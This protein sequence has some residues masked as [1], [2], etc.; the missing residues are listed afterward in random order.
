MAEFVPLVEAL[1][2]GDPA[3]EET[4]VGPLIDE[5]ARERVL[6]WI[7]ETSGEVLT[8]GDTTEEGSSAQP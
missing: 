6:E 7:A 3:D 5:D 4:D 1:T 2:V 8:G